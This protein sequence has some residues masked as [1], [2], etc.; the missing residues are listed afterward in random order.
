MALNFLMTTYIAASVRAL[1]RDQNGT[2]TTSKEIGG[3]RL[4]S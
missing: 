3:H 1:P 2:R 4:R